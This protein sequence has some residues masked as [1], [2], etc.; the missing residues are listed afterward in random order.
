VTLL[1]DR[2]GAGYSRYRVP[3][4]RIQAA[5]LDALGD[6]ASIV[7]VGAGVGS[8]EPQDRGVVAVE[9][10]ATMAAQRPEGAAPCVRATAEG[11]PFL[12]GAFDA[13]LAVLTMH[14]WTDWRAGLAELRR[15][16][17]RRLVVF[18]WTPLAGAYWF[19]RDYLSFVYERDRAAFPS[20]DEFARISGGTVEVRPVPIPWDC[21]D[22]FLGAYWRRPEA[23]L[24]AGRARATSALADPA[25]PVRAALTRLAADLE[26]GRWAARNADLLAAETLDVGYRLLVVR[27]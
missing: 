1:Y 19:A 12:D 18:T 15:V 21:T 11:L 22:G 2:I 26:S 5:I 20:L 23:Y 27:L 9:P 7:N 25:P 16:S 10:T 8:Y 3:D 6:A 4:P 14:H 17:R 24:D 13:G